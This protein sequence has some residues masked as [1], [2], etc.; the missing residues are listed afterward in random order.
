MYRCLQVIGGIFR[1]SCPKAPLPPTGLSTQHSQPGCTLPTVCRVNPKEK[2]STSIRMGE[3][4][5]YFLGW[6][7]SWRY[8]R[9]F[10]EESSG[11]D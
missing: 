10:Q 5:I 4:L 2:F 1:K 3:T 7:G 6:E 11:N 9:D 8:C